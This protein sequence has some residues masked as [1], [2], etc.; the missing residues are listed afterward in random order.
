[1]RV[2]V[3]GYRIRGL[4]GPACVLHV[5]LAAAEDL[6]HPAAP[7]PPLPLSAHTA[8]APQAAGQPEHGPHLQV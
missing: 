3:V 1:M 5:G 2:S 6:P 7:L 8:A 4:L